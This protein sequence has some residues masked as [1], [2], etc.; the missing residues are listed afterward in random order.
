MAPPRGW[1]S[2]KQ[3]V[4]VTSLLLLALHACLEAVAIAE[5]FHDVHVMGQSVQ[6]CPGHALIVGKHL[7]PLE[8]IL[9]SMAICPPSKSDCMVTACAGTTKIAYATN[10][11]TALFRRLLC[12][13]MMCSPRTPL[14]PDY[15]GLPGTTRLALDQ[16]QSPVGPMI[17][18]LCSNTRL[19]CRFSI[20]VRPDQQ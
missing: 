15:P 20:P 10:A 1:A 12:L 5:D 11:T 8:N 6:Q 13:C 14:K 19:C 7:R 16:S 3:L 2:D 9:S 18:S 17:P 4:G